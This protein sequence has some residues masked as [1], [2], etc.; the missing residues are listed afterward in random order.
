MLSLIGFAT[1]LVIVVLLLTGKVSPIIGLVLVPIAGA[2]AAGFA[3]TEI[4]AFFS[5][6]IVKVLG[7]VTMFIFAILYF[8]LMNDVGLFDPLINRMIAFTR[9]N[10]IS[11]CLGT[12]L[13]G[14]VAHLDGSGAT[15]FLIAMPPLLPLYQR[16][17][18]SPYLLMLLVST[19]AAVINMVPWGGP[20]GRAAAVLK[21]DPVLLWRPLIPLQI[22]AM[23]LLLG[24]A[25][26][27][28]L[29]EKRRIARMAVTP[30]EGAE[31]DAAEADLAPT[32]AP[33]AAL[34]RPGLLWF[35]SLLTV[36]MLV[37][38]VWGVVP[39]EL[40]FMVA[41]SIA[42]A[43]NFPNA[44]DQM[45]RIKAHAPNAL[46]MAAILLA[47]GSFLGILDG[48]AMLTAIATDAVGIMPAAMS[49]DLHLWV[50]AF[51]IPI[52]LLL[53]TDAFFFALMPVVEKIV[54][55]F[56]VDPVAAAYPMIIGKVTGTFVCPLAPAVWLALG[57]GNLDMGKHLRYS[58][59]WV[60]G[61]SIVLLGVAWLMGMFPL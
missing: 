40:T 34:A 43:V 23:I 17:R 14:A 21:M 35:N 1:I 25:V 59:F 7:V 52:E 36:A 19:S 39:S 27:L 42:L 29:R 4:G 47:A 28:G 3:V 54:Q 10:I 55:G 50:G 12:V 44:K 53:N 61:F 37:F 11:V 5:S 30:V 58:F 15:T 31:A 46:L 18:M 49:Q 45:S 20:L 6:G 60:W 13:I 24:M 9:G 32:H 2:L 57:I 56:G 26:I 22:I 33:A 41:A 38:L 51:G 16:L 48:T 8:G